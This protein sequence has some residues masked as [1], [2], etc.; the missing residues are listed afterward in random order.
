MLIAI[1]RSRRHDANAQPRTPPTFAPDTKGRF[2]S[3]RAKQRWDEQR[4]F[5]S[6][7]YQRWQGRRWGI[8]IWEAMMGAVG[9]ERRAVGSFITLYIWPFWVN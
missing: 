3:I 9:H 5:E 1:F 4:S 2:G 6:N 7:E 8:C